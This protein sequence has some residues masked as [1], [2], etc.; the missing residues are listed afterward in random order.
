LKGQYGR[1]SAVAAGADGALYVTTSNRETW[2]PGNDVVIKLTDQRI[3][4]STDQRINGSADQ[5]L[6]R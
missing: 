4:G 5:R 6:T 3:N 2:G 1:L